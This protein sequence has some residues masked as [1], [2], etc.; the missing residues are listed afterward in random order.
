[1]TNA[2]EKNQVVEAFELWRHNRGSRQSPTLQALRKQAVD[3]LEHC[4][5]SKVTSLLR[6]CGSQLKQWREFVKSS[7]TTM[8]LSASQRKAKR[9]IV[10][11]NIPES[12]FFL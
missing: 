12:H 3:L 10:L 1:M 11:I 6:I 8:I 7:Q 9:I 5:C 4:S 2:K